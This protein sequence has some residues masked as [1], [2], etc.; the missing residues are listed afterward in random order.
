M[1]PE[2]YTLDTLAD[3]QGE[4]MAL[5]IFRLDYPQHSDHDGNPVIHRDRVEEL[6]ALIQSEDTHDDIDRP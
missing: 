5:K 3:E 2:Y 4:D 1:T 6:L